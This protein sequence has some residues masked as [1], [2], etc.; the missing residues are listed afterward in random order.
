MNDDN[1]GLIAHD[2]DEY[3]VKDE[4]AMN[5]HYKS[6]KLIYN[7]YHFYCAFIDLYLD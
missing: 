7:D 3:V 5:R 4:Y 1:S 2:C 6:K